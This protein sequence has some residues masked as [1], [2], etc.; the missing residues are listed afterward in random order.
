MK[1]LI[2]KPSS[3]GDVIHSIPVARM[4]ARHFPGAEIDWWLNQD[5]IPL[6]SGDPDLHQLIAFD[7]RRWATPLGWPHLL[8]TIRQLRARQYDW[9]LDLQSLAR[10]AALA[11]LVNADRTVGLDDRREGAPAAYDMAVARRT[12]STHAVDWYLDVLRAMDVPIRWDFDWIPPR[13]AVAASLRSRWFADGQQWVVFQPGA[14]WLNKRWP[15]ESFAQLATLLLRGHPNRRIAILGGRS[16]APLAA[17]IIASNPQRCVNFCG[18][19]SLPEMVEFLRM[20]RVMITNDTG[21]MHAA[22]AVGL[23]VIGLFGPTNPLRTGPYGQLAHCLQATLPCIPCMKPTC[24]HAISLECLLQLAPAAVAHA[25][26][27]RLNT[28]SPE[29]AYGIRG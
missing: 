20:S 27:E 16:D 4:L 3:L 15:S 23:P 22:V 21:P 17:P 14:R 8:K 5:L 10:S 18:D 12:P 29:P 11:W 2:L 28:R 9:I 19:L 1:I 25:V 13:D 24:R 7:R 26:E 6:L